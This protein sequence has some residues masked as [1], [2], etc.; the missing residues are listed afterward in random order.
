[1]L[2]I[3]IQQV[4]L[5]PTLQLIDRHEGLSNIQHSLRLFATI[6]DYPETNPTPDLWP[7]V[8]VDELAQYGGHGQTA[9]GGAP[10]GGPAGGAPAGGAPASSP[11]SIEATCAPAAAASGEVCSSILW[12]SGCV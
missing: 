12:C 3:L 10:A 11:P 7:G 2:I 4:L 9:T 6:Q 1:M 5:K 8:I